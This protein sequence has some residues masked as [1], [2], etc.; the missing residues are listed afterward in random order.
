MLDIDRA[1]LL[2]GAAGGAV[3]DDLVRDG[4][5]EHFPAGLRLPEKEPA[6]I[7]IVK[8]LLEVLDDLFRVECLA[9]E[10]SGAGVLA[11]PAAGA[12]VKV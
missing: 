9:A 10:I 4:L 6:G 1:G 5:A 8:V 11:A 2:A 7:D 12:G 3:P